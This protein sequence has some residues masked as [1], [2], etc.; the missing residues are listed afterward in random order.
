MPPLPPPAFNQPPDLIPPVEM[1]KEESLRDK[2]YLNNYQRKPT[3]K[4]GHSNKKESNQAITF[5]SPEYIARKRTNEPLMRFMAGLAINLAIKTRHPERQNEAVK[6][7]EL[8]R[9]QALWGKYT[10]RALHLTS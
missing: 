7:A 5:L 10:K 4:S 9:L 3:F 8:G 2:V 6:R 1:P